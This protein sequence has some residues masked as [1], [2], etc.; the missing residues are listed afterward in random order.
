MAATILEMKKETQFLTVIV[1]AK[2]HAEV[3]SPT[4]AKLVA[5][6][7]R[8]N[9]YTGGIR[10]TSQPYPVDAEGKLVQ[11]IGRANAKMWRLDYKV[12]ALNQ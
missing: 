12:Q 9:G 10:R 7:G 2:S 5:K 11:Q 4:T 6:V 1:E 8:E 3:V